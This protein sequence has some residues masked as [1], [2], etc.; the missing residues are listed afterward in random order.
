MQGV[1]G[2]GKGDEAVCCL[3]HSAMIPNLLHIFFNYF[4]IIIKINLYNCH[5]DFRVFMCYQDGCLILLY[6]ALVLVV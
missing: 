3:H 6:F 1:Q 2:I 4:K 5:I